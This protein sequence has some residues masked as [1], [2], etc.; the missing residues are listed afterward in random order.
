MTRRVFV[1]FALK[2][3]TAIRDAGCWWFADGGEDVSGKGRKKEVGRNG[4]QRWC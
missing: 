3:K 4:G 1:W 2:G